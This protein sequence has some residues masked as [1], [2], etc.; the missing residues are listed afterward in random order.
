MSIGHH[1]SHREQVM[2]GEHP[3]ATLSMPEDLV[4]LRPTSKLLQEQK[5]EEDKMSAVATCLRMSMTL[6][7]RPAIPLKRHLI[8]MVPLVREI[9]LPAVWPLRRE[10]KP[11]WGLQH[12]K[13]WAR[14]RAQRR[15]CRVS[16][17]PPYDYGGWQLR[18]SGCV[19]RRCP[20]ASAEHLPEWPRLGSLHPVIQTSGKD[21]PAATGTRAAG[22]SHIPE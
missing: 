16:L 1:K 21:S 15:T 10:V 7:F 13:E 14:S 18:T 22:S 8:G 6:G 12:C 17:P 2:G 3:V 9:T 19:S 20:T 11:E 4:S 5:D